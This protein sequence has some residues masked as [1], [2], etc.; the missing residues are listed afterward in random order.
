MYTGGLENHPK[1]IEEWSQYCPLW[2][3]PAGVLPRVREPMN[4]GML[5]RSPRVQTVPHVAEGRWLVKPLRGAGGRGIR[6]WEGG[7]IRRGEYLQE[8]VEGESRSA[9]YFATDAGCE[10]LG[11]TRQLIGVEWLH[12]KPFQY[13][14][15]IGPL[16]LT[17]PERDHWQAI[18]DALWSVGL[19]TLFGVDA[20]WH[21]GEPWIVEVNPRYTAAVEVLEHALGIAC[22]AGG[23]P[24]RPGGKQVA[25]G[26]AIYFAPRSLRF[27]DRGS[28]D[29]DLAVTD[30]WR[31]PGY[32]DIPNPGEAFAAGEPVVTL[33]AT[34]QVAGLEAKLQDSSEAM[35]G[36]FHHR[37]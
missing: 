3:V 5:L 37:R 25:V 23:V 15:N 13:C 22:L 35:N 4:L 30:V 9:I 20:I 33:F 1:L 14:G 34:G 7:P 19:R 11:V 8:W 26:K 36:L 6:E 31:L 18:G 32:A 29:A 10:L 17:P 28:W 27:P 2:G 16:P 24:K 12:A 21:C